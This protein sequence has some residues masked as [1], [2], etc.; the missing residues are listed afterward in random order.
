M[1]AAEEARAAFELEGCPCFRCTAEQISKRPV[2]ERLI[3]PMVVCDTCGN[4][5]CPHAEHHDNPCTGSN[6]PGQ[7]GADRY[8]RLTV[9]EQEREELILS[10]LT[11]EAP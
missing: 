9:T 2:A 11:K 5:R 7:P 3:Y 1:S 6:E 10:F 4:K 8:Q